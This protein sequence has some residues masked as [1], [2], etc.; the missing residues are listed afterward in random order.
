M[1]KSVA[2]SVADMEFC[3]WTKEDIELA[4]SNFRGFAIE[5]T[6]NPILKI[7]VVTHQDVPTAYPNSINPFV[8]DCRGTEMPDHRWEVGFLPDGNDYI[9][10]DYFTDHL[11]LEWIRLTYGK[12]E[13]TLEVVCRN[14]QSATIDPYIYPLANILI[15]KM[16]R[17]VKSFLIHS[18]VVNDGGKGYLFTA[19]SGT[20]KSTMARIW[21]GEGS[22]IVNDDMLAL[23]TD[24]KGITAY[25]IPMYQYIDFQR[26]VELNGIFLISQ[27]KVNFIRPI[28]GAQAALRL[29]SNTIS[30]PS[31]E[32]VA[33]EHIS[34]VGLVASKVPIFELGFKPDSDIVSMV[35]NLNL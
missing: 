26:S 3:F 7:E 12:N 24:K 28:S 19:V 16:L 10:V 33:K 27:S 8:G 30:Q 6:S 2:V 23:R 5:K 13:G 4:P 14:R 32:V 17:R 9:M 11:P 25:N 20:G 35:R 15:S 22:T 18:S 34:N 31:S 21:K 1:S 29:A